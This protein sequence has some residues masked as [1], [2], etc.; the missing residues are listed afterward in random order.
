MK[1]IL[2]ILGWSLVSLIT[3]LLIIITV[4]VSYL[5][6]KRL[7]PI[8][9]R[10][11][12][13]YLTDARLSVERIEI[14]FW[15]TFPRFDLDIRGLQLHSH[16]FDRLPSATRDSLPEFADS[17]LSF[18]HLNAGVNIPR[19]LAG[20][21][22]LYDITLESPAANI[23]IATPECS[24]FDIFPPSDDKKKDD[25]P[26]EI[27]DFSMGTFSIIGSMPVR[28]VSVPDSIDA[29]VCLS[30]TSLDGN[31]APVYSL[32]ITGDAGAT[33]P[34]VS[35][36]DIRIGIGG[37]IDWSTSHPMRVA[38]DDFRISLGDVSTVVDTDLDFENDFCIKSFAL[39]L[40]ETP[41][42]SI[43]ALIP[44]DM[45]GELDKLDTNLSIALGAE[46][47]RPFTVGTDSLPSF[48]LNVN[49]PEG[50]AEYD[51]M[52]LSR[53]ELKAS[54][55]IDGDNLDRSTIDISRLMAVGEGIGFSLSANASDIIS[56]PHV[57][58]KF[59]GG[60]NI[61]R[62]PRVILSTLPGT[63][64][65]QLRADCDFDLRKSYLD[66][67]L[68]HKIRLTGDATL[69]DLLV[70]MPELPVHVYSNE[71]QLHLGTNTSF[72]R[73]DVSVD[74][75]LTMSLSVDSVA[76]IME[77]LDL[78]G[79]GIKIGVGCRNTSS[80][81]D[82][83][84][85]NPIGG[86]IQANRISLRTPAD[87]TRIYLR[88]ASIGGALSR[89]KGN[90]RQPQLLLNISTSSA[91]YADRI[92]RAM[93]S[94]ANASL[95][96]HPSALPSAQ[97]RFAMMDSL[98]KAHP[99][100]SRDSLQALSRKIT[101]ERYASRRVRND[102]LRHAPAGNDDRAG[103]EVDRSLR[104]MLRQWQASG[105]LKSERMRLFTP[106]FP[107]RNR[108]DS[109][110]IDFTTDSI[111]IHETHVQVGH[112]DFALDGSISNISKALTSRNGSQSLIA[113][114]NLRSDT[115]N[116]NELAAA[117]FAGAAFADR[118][119]TGIIAIAAPV[120][121]NTGEQQLQSSLDMT[122]AA[123]DSTSVLIIPA[124]LEATVDV[125]A[126]HIV[127]SDLVFHDFRGTLNAF[128]G[129]LNLA[130]LGARSD[131]GALNLNALYTAPDKYDASFAF[132]LKVDGF[133]IREFL[134]LV[135]A[136][137]SL[138]P[139]LQDFDGIIN[140]DIAATTDLDT[141]MNIEIPSLKAAVRLS[142]DSLVVMDK[143]TFRKIGKWLLFKD[144]QHN[145][146]DSMTVEMIVDNSQLQMFPF[147]FNLDRYKLGIA[148]SNDLAMNLNYHIAV[149]K[150]PLP[151]KFGI[152]VSGTPDDMKIRLGKAKFNEKNMAR[153][154]SIADTTRVNLVRE[155]R[156]VFSRGV[157]NSR[158][159]RL[160]INSD[161][162]RGADNTAVDQSADTISRADSLYFIRE[163]LLPAPPAPEPTTD[164][165]KK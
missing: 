128:D 16:V 97:R 124:N 146:I 135:P 3:I 84:V 133:H 13:E 115:I 37:D 112:S 103:I 61:A 125:K 88:E 160:I 126:G 5:T 143:E 141:A 67:E 10:Y 154:V 52:K 11:A 24:N 87:S 152:N 12:N 33:L 136:I 150:S 122:T 51:G 145:M 58:G 2:K 148:G 36:P 64:K 114:L 147:M 6:P 29:S 66:R 76:C 40:S 119:T 137:D 69:K 162:M 65:G 21:I 1:R 131:I 46:L 28:Y 35:I 132:G 120:D 19:L 134:D 113:R 104:Q 158:T 47:T 78:R 25:S 102:S 165:K 94:G 18:S 72:V 60:L 163:G 151:F 156:N 81:S 56:D 109:L 108:I 153:T 127:Y 50:A 30:V 117:V 118:D 86:R 130:Q 70:E 138:M 110:N 9:E 144:K 31:N 164:K 92:N 59:R 7:T 22:A 159:E 27:P 77:D 26:I 34:S 53:F 42:S 96:I 41:V 44:P 99:T 71:M 105:S 73:D 161:A 38:L 116:V 63:V 140:A 101:R 32:D 14:S 82:T 123:V 157:R 74:S 8:V 155:I 45:R 93:L 80:S 121:E 43:I 79:H 20:N 39:S 139:L 17:L 107:L 4:A 68:F 57:S 91:L 55:D 142:G 100:L 83:T 111:H 149:L 15:S 75:L 90:A 49:V 48:T 95:T 85:I 54:A 23:V 106:L 62:L 89:F 98:R 129:A